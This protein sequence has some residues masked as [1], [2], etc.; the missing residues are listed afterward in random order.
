MSPLAHI[1]LVAMLAVLYRSVRV[2]FGG[3]VC[4]TEGRLDGAVALVYPAD[5]DLGL[6]TTRGLA[7]RGATVVMACSLVEKC[8]RARRQLLDQ[9]G[10]GSQAAL[11]NFVGESK[12]REDQIST[13]GIIMPKQASDCIL[14]CTCTC[15][16][17][18]RQT[19]LQVWQL[20]HVSAASIKEFCKKFRH[21]FTKLNILVLNSVYMSKTFDKTVDGLE[22]HIGLNFVS[23]YLLAEN[24]LPLLRRSSTA[25]LTSRLVFVS[26]R[27]HAFG[28][29]P[30]GLTEPVPPLPQSF[31]WW[32]AYTSSQLLTVT[33]ASYL[34]SRDTQ[35]K[36]A[37]AVVHPGLEA[38]L[39]NKVF[40][41]PFGYIF[42]WFGKSAWQ[43]AQTT[44][45]FLLQQQNPEDL[46]FAECQT[47]ELHLQEAGEDLLGRV[48]NDL[49]RHLL[50]TVYA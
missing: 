38:G 25:A 49:K 28:T 11:D 35:S 3:C 43:A 50:P 44:L 15:S 26:S 27:L 23:S 2:Y 46:Y 10:P 34:K 37:I 14:T 39:I 4:S 19:A 21:K 5:S 36:V 1:L 33:Y 16:K 7:R 8:N 24:L 32:K 31:D 45:A 42:S 47:A 9:F 17:T 13:V 41:K 29:L 22:R 6:L 40:W 20:H 18:T 48:R 12:L 30:E